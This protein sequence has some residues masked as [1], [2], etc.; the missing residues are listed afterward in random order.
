ML[1]CRL[2]VGTVMQACLRSRSSTI[3]IMATSVR[4]TVSYEGF[5]VVK[6]SYCA[7]NVS[8][9]GGAGNAGRANTPRYQ[10]RSF[11]MSRFG[12]KANSNEC[13]YV[14]HKNSISKKGSRSRKLHLS[15]TTHN[16][17]GFGLPS[18]IRASVLGRPPF[19]VLVSGYDPRCSCCWF[20]VAFC[21]SPPGHTEYRPPNWEVGQAARK[22]Y[23]TA[24]F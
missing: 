18:Q 3:P 20:S 17:D 15:R 23:V 24:M 11:I 7:K 22:I 21:K 16:D 13:K 4:S 8:I 14:C 12:S 19:A 10:M 2:T 6:V 1:L 9:C 5:E